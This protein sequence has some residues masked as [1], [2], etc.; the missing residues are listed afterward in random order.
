MKEKMTHSFCFTELGIL[1]Q[2]FNAFQ[3]RPS[4]CY[5]IMK[6]LETY[7]FA[8]MQDIADACK[9]K[10][11]ND[12]GHMLR[13]MESIGVIEKLPNNGIFSDKR[14]QYVY[15]LNPHISNIKKILSVNHRTTS[16]LAELCGFKNNTGFREF[17]N[18]MEN[19]GIVKVKYTIGKTKR[20]LVWRLGDFA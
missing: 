19:L 4:T 2:L 14:I 1:S 5:K 7:P 18:M 20:I 16:E 11:R 13:V 9:Y 8:C 10:N 6:F 3:K 15:I 17:I 12:I